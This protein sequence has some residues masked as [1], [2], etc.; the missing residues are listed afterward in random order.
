L[1]TRSSSRI[2][3]Q[4]K[5]SG[6]KTPSENVNEKTILKNNLKLVNNE[7]NF[8]NKYDEQTIEEKIDLR[9]KSTDAREKRALRRLDKLNK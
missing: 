4:L 5:A 7:N 6:S 3:Q 9:K 1:Q 2:K 8:N